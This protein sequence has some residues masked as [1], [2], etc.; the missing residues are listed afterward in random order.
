MEVWCL[1]ADERSYQRLQEL[2]EPLRD[3]YRIDLYTTRP[4]GKKSDDARDPPPS[5]WEN[6]ELRSYLGDAFGRSKLAPGFATLPE[7]DVPPLRDTLALRMLAYADQTLE[8]NR[9]MKRYAL[10]LPALTRVALD[11]STAPELR[12][13]ALSV[14]MA[15]A[16]NLAKYAGKLEA[17]LT[18][19]FPRPA[20]ADHAFSPPERSSSAGNTPEDWAEK[21][22]VTAQ[23]V[24]RRVY[25]FI[26]PEHYAVGLDELRNP[27]LLKALSAL[28]GTNLSFQKTLAKAAPGQAIKNRQSA[29]GG[30]Q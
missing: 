19:A 24:A 13:Q 4:A 20:K 30:R 9:K 11:A 5:L 7:I 2:L 1:V 6:D 22:S 14:C 27:G 18:Q 21:V 28:E 8:W 10:D 16:Q 25:D 15:H 29:S 23:N 26:H 17:N 3:S 12:L